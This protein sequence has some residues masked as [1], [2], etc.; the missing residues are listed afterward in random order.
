M[1]FDVKIYIKKG[2]YKEKLVVP[3]WVQHIELI[4]EDV[5]NTII[6]H[7]DHA[8]MNHMGTFR[9]YTVKVEGNYITF[10]NITI[11]NNAPRLGQAVALHTEGDCLRFINCR[12]L[13]N[14]DTV[15]TGVEGTRLYFENCYIEGTTDFIFGPSTAWFEGC[16]IHS[17]ANSYITA[18]S[19]P[20]DIEYGYIFNKCKLTATA[21]VDKVYLGRPWRPYA[22]TIFMNCELGKHIV[23]AGWDNWRDAKNEKAARYAEYHNSGEG[24]KVDN[25]VKWAKQLS[26]KE[27]EKITTVNCYNLS[28]GWRLFE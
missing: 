23:G 25:R 15:Y 6:T 4:G 19:T 5:Q 28:K 1:D 24:A 7:A 26:D 8:N 17:K 3:S 18:A 10:R 21:G 2:I 20:K 12:F 14:Q 27:A 22:Y 13:G 11:E 16:T 9:T